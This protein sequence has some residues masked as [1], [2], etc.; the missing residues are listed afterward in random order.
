M[1]VKLDTYYS[2]GY[3]YRDDPATGQKLVTSHMPWGSPSHKRTT[4]NWDLSYA[5]PENQ[6]TGWTI[7]YGLE[8]GLHYDLT[9]AMRLYYGTVGGS[10]HI[11]FWHASVDPTGAEVREQTQEVTEWIVAPGETSHTHIVHNWK[12]WL[13]PGQRLRVELDM[14]NV[15]DSQ[16]MRYVGGTVRGFYGRPD[17]ATPPPP[18]GA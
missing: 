7:L 15:P 6:R 12:A 10:G 8:T 11:G 9:V 16:P 5:D 17:A 1:G 2:I 13:P 4:V 18:P 14:W 3:S